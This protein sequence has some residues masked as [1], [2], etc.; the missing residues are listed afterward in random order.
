MFSRIICV[1]KIYTLEKKK[2]AR[3]VKFEKKLKNC[4]LGYV[5]VKNGG[6]PAYQ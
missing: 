1:K 4:I 5:T 3:K 6:S 2:N